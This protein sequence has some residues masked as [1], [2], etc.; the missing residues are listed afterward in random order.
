MKNI[1]FIGTSHLVAFKKG[2][3]LISQ[4]IDHRAVF[5]GIS[6]PQLTYSLSQGAWV[7]RGKLLVPSKLVKYYIEYVPVGNEESNDH[8]MILETFIPDAIVLVDM[9]FWYSV[10]TRFSREPAG[11]LTFDGAPISDTC[12]SEMQVQGMGYRALNNHHRFGDLAIQSVMPLLNQIYKYS[13]SNCD[14]FLFA[15]PIP[16]Q[17][18]LAHREITI[19]NSSLSFIEETFT[20]VLSKSGFKFMKQERKTI[21]NQLA[22]NDNYSIGPSLKNPKIPDIHCNADFGLEHIKSLLSCIS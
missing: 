16:H 8:E 7:E 21:T 18:R 5:I 15:S 1:L 4:D 19:N 11:L 2:W 9:Q 17:S 22:T 14:L 6:G 20:S 12:F 13:K 10:L 3:E